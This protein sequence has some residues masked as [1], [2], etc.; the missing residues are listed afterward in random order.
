MEKVEHAVVRDIRSPVKYLPDPLWKSP[1]EIWRALWTALMRDR[2]GFVKALIFVANHSLPRPRLYMSHRFI[3]ACLLARQLHQDGIEHVHS[4]FAGVATDVAL[5]ASIVTGIPFSFTGHAIDVFTPMRRLLRD[6][7]AA[8]EFVTTCTGASAAHLLKVAGSDQGHKIH[9]AYHGVDIE[10]FSW[11]EDDPA[12]ELPLVLSVG[13][14]VKIKGHDDLVRALALLRDRGLAF[15]AV[16]IGEGPERETLEEQVRQFGLEAVVTLP[17]A[18]SQD[19]LVGVYRDASVFVLACRV[20]KNDRDGLPNVILEAMSTGLPVITT[21]VSGIPEVVRDGIN[22]LLVPQRDPK[23]LMS[24]IEQLLP[25]GK[26]RRRLGRAAR[27][28]I[29]EEMDARV[30][31][32]PLLSLYTTAIGQPVGDGAEATVKKAAKPER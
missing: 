1:G 9:L 21:P 7:I 15:R 22:G 30:T 25:D 28:T 27:E 32:R 14:L 16:I 18:V 5:L 24:A 19:D 10:K 11:R 8:A 2:V 17:G 13:R 3:Y 6:K 29:V 12:S 26:A 4:H 23:A 20:L 31:V